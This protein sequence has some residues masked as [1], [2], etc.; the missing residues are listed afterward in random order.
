MSK[1]ITNLYFN[2]EKKIIKCGLHTNIIFVFGGYSW[3]GTV[4]NLCFMCKT[5]VYNFSKVFV[6]YRLH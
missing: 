5:T 1:L 6:I 3:F 4:R 2:K